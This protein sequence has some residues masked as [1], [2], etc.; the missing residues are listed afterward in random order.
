MNET[1]SE[2]DGCLQRCFKESR[3]ADWLKDVRHRMVPET[4]KPKVNYDNVYHIHTYLYYVLCIIY[5]FIYNFK[6]RK[7]IT[8]KYIFLV[9]YNPECN[10]YKPHI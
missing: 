1:V 6:L 4:Y 8:G 3:A 2:I 9:F 5:I 7:I 10:P